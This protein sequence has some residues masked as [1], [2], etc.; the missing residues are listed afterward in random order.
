M[1]SVNNTE[2]RMFSD[3]QKSIASNQTSE[4]MHGLG[5]IFIV[6]G[7]Q[8][9]RIVCGDGVTDDAMGTG[10]LKFANRLKNGPLPFESRFQLKRYLKFVMQTAKLDVLKSEKRQSRS[11]AGDTDAQS[12]SGRP[13]DDDD[14]VVQAGDWDSEIP[15]DASLEPI[16]FAREEIEWLMERAVDS[17]E[18]RELVREKYLEGRSD[19]EIA[20]RHGMTP[21]QVRMRV[22]RAILAMKK[23][24]ECEGNQSDSP[25]TLLAAQP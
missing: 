12:E 22:H 24:L 14:I 25:E 4:R 18:D 20:E 6:H 17:V 11:P 15:D 2:D 13:T 21:A 19:D 23:F 16:M 3:I 7:S 5:T 8:L 1:D 9:R 10:M